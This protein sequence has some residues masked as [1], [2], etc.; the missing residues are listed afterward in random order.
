MH[1]F[2]ITTHSA[3]HSHDLVFSFLKEVNTTIQEFSQ[4]KSY[5]TSGPFRF[6]SNT[7]SNDPSN[8]DDWVSVDC[9]EFDTKDDALNF[10]RMISSPDIAINHSRPWDWNKGAEVIT[11]LGAHIKYYIVGPDG[12]EEVL[13]DN[14]DLLG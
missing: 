11:Q 9:W 1:K 2:Y 14:K 13:Y 4:W 8:L 10:Y 5:I 7:V 6:L 3:Q 12:N